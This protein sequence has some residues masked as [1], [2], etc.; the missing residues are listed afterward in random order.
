MFS[1]NNVDLL[2]ESIEMPSEIREG[3]DLPG[4]GSLLYGQQRQSVSMEPTGAWL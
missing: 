3:A 1:V 2:K 4:P